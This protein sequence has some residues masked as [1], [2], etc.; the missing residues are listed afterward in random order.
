MLSWYRQLLSLRRARAELS[1]PRPSSTSVEVDEER[2]VVVMRRGATVVLANLADESVSMPAHG[3]ILA[4]SAR[5]VVLD[6][7][8]AIIPPHSVAVIA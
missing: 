4:S 8:E 2:K 7:D 3:T 5:G 1:D 6:G